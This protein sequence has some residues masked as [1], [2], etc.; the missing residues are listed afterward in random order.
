MSLKSIKSALY[1]IFTGFILLTLISV[2]T[3]WFSFNQLKDNQLNLV[4]SHLPALIK[5]Q[6][7]V[8]ISSQLSTLTNKLLTAK[9]QSEL[10][11][12]WES[13]QTK[14]QQLARLLDNYKALNNTQIQADINPLLNQLNTNLESIYDNILLSLE[15]QQV[16]FEA[17]IR[18]EWL[19][20]DTVDEITPLINDLSFN[21]EQTLNSKLITTGSIL[22]Q[23]IE[24]L[25]LFS[26]IL[27]QINLINGIVTQTVDS[28]DLG[29]L[30]TSQ[31][32]I[33]Q[34]IDQLRKDS[35]KLE[36]SATNIAVIQSINDY[37]GLISGDDNIYS[38]SQIKLELYKRSLGLVDINQ[39]L[40]STLNE[41]IKQNASTEEKAA[42]DKS[43]QIFKQ[44]KQSQFILVII[45]SISLFIAI[46]IGWLY[47]KNSLVRRILNLNDNMQA[48][49][50]GQMDQTIATQGNDEITNMAKSLKTFRDTLRET[51]KELIQA[52]KLAAL[53]QL[54]AGVAHELNQPLA[55]I[56]NYTHNSMVLIER[57]ETAQAN[58]TLQH[59]DNLTEHMAEIITQF[60]QFSRKPSAQIKPISLSQAIA[61]VLTILENSI[62]KNGIQLTLPQNI[63]EIKV[64]A[65]MI[66]LEQVLV[67]VISNAIDALADSE[68]KKIIINCD[69]DDTEKMLYL[70]I[71]DS[72]CGIPKEHREQ[73][74]E[75][76]YST[77]KSKGL[78]LGLSI[79][80]NIM[81]DFNGSLECAF[82]GSKGSTFILSLK[83]ATQ[84]QKP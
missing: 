34:L 68:L 32:Y 58:K 17:K 74:F 60:K 45:F 62:A 16:I 63:K 33:T 70:S 81:K 80:Y 21:L 28:T 19:K 41:K 83:Q 76:F 7:M 84:T 10:N 82:S 48:I 56:R 20:I 42:L 47:V 57:G 24:K 13:L 18:L 9:T 2:S 71:S 61:N 23:H 40:L 44:I 67:N 75:P 73:I 72:G 49:A 54:S 52:G 38:K 46:L 65:E 3:S 55:A 8:A 26:S 14:S 59:I 66:R 5:T 79:S 4:N 27:N 78:G 53:G 1:L 11:R 31:L 37:F 64:N 25:T 39:Q 12:Q 50:Q 6:E 35:T 30:M 69:T 15:I 77:K 36:L 29:S 43:L 22:N 51:Q